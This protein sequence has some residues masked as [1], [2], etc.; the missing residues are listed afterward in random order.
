MAYKILIVDDEDSI[1]GLLEECLR[2]A[3]YE[4]CTAS[5]PYDGLHEIVK[6]RPDLVVSDVWMP[7]MDGYAFCKLI[8]KNYHAPVILMTGV[9]QEMRWFQD[10]NSGA[11]DYI[12]KPIDL[13][14]L[15]SRISN[16]LKSASA[17]RARVAV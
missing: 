2:Q 11:D 16:I 17:K 3:G 10:V 12:A 7:R 5:N 15:L 4:I 14:E 9:P 6:H 1:R 13:T 8:K